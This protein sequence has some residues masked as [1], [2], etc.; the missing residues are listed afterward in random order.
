MSMTPPSG[1]G[2]FLKNLDIIRH[3]LYSIYFV[4]STNSISSDSS[5]HLHASRKLLGFLS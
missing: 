3:L 1:E 5:S 4:H 2:F